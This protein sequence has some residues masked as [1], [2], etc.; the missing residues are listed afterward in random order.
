MTIISIVIIMQSIVTLGIWAGRTGGEKQ[1]GRAPSLPRWQSPPSGI[2]VK[3]DII[4]NIN[5]NINIAIN[6]IDIYN[7][8]NSDKVRQVAF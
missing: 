5:I 4:N 8:I 3:K 1:K 7:N 2:L 6:N